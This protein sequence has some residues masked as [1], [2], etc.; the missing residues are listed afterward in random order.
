VTPGGKA[1]VIMRLSEAPDLA[2]VRCVWE[3]IGREYQECP[4]IQR[5]KNSLKQQFERQE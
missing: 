1:F 5:H 4:A 2:A 3:S